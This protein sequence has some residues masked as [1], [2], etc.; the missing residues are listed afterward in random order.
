MTTSEVLENHKNFI[1]TDDQL[2][3]ENEP[4]SK[5][6]YFRSLL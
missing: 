1:G 6:K 3:T 5:V 4:V 2:L